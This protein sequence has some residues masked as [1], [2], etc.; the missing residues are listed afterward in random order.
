MECNCVKADVCQH[1]LELKEF[2]RHILHGCYPG[3]CEAQKDF[4][5]Q[6]RK[7]CRFRVKADNLQVIE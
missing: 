6:V 1:R 3:P 5:H 2:M 4:W 7:H